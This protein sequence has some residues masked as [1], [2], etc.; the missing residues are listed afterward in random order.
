M[1]S[2]K[3]ICEGTSEAHALHRIGYAIDG[4]KRNSGDPYDWNAPLVITAFIHKVV[5]SGQWDNVQDD[6]KRL[7][8]VFDGL[9]VDET[10]V[11]TKRMPNYRTR[12]IKHSP[13]FQIN[14]YTN[15]TA[16]RPPFLIEIIPAESVVIN[17]W[18]TIL[19]FIHLWFPNIK[20]SMVDYAIDVYCCDFRA[21]E[22]LFRVQLKHLFIPYQRE[23]FVY[24][25]DMVQYG[26]QTRMNSVC[27]IDD[28]KIY[29]RGPDMKRNGKGWNMKDVDRVRLEYS[30][31]RRVLFKKGISVIADLIRHPQFYVINKNVYR[32]MHFSGSKKLPRLGQDY[33]M[34]DKNGKVGYFQSEDIGHR[35]NVKNIAHYRKDI[36]EFAI[37]KSA[38]WDA[39]RMFDFEWVGEQGII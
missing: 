37:V 26:N 1:L 5:L 38:L 11:P 33:T 3:K 13:E 9:F 30:A 17:D 12:W 15:P 2:R 28:V 4:I 16:K 31:P 18:K 7:W 23:A 35:K 22:K 24:G 19:K 10:F 32:F 14:I 21:A 20:V 27:R 34:P 8:T 39:M 6:Y 36:E 29:E 25:G